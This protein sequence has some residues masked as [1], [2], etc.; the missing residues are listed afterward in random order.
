[1]TSREIV[2]WRKFQNGSGRIGGLN[3]LMCPHP[4]PVRLS[5]DC[6]SIVDARHLS[7]AAYGFLDVPGNLLAGYLGDT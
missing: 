6:G 3:A 4:L 7:F 1:M 5:R 2:I